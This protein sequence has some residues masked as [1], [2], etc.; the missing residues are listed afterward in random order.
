MRTAPLLAVASISLASISLMAQQAE[1]SFQQNATANS[2]VH[3]SAQGSATAQAKTG[4]ASISG[5]AS[6][7]GTASSAADSSLRAARTEEMSSVS[8][9]LEGKLD[10]KTAKAGDQ[11]VLKTTEKVKAADGTVIPKGTRLIGHVTA[12]QAHD[13]AHAES[14]LGITF[15]RAELKSGQSV[16]I[17]STIQTVEPRPS[18]AAQSS[19]ADDDMFAGPVGGGMASGHAMTAGRIGGGLAGGAV[20][21][22]GV[23]T[24]NAGERV[25][26]NAAGTVHQTA[27]AEQGTERVTG[28][29]AASAGANLRGVG[30]ASSHMA[31]RASEHATMRTTGIPGVMLR[32]GASGSASGTLSQSNKNVHLDSGTQMRLSFATAAK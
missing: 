1:S 4:S 32:T 11:V 19:M 18:I 29:T 2:S 20:E 12:A 25:S 8:G 14:Q 15:D 5:I 27:N 3:E 23:A 6:N 7:T 22:T 16:A 28:S 10:T 21:R 17:H 26:S 30:N 13:S 31:G 9:E 24:L